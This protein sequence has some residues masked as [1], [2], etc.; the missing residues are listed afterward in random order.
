[1]CAI[2]A[3]RRSRRV[4]L[5]DHADKVGQ[6]ILISGGGRCNFT[7]LNVTPEN[8]LSQ[9]R[10]FCISALKRY[11]QHDFVA[12]IR[13]HNIPYH[14]R[15]DGQ[16]FCDRSSQDIINMLLKEC[17]D[18]NVVLI[19]SCGSLKVKKDSLFYIGSNRERF[20]AGSLVIATG[21]LSFQKKEAIGFGY[22]I[23]R[24]FGLNVVDL[25]PGL[26]PL[27]FNSKDIAS[28]ND[29]A[30]ISI[31]AAVSCNNKCFKGGILF[32]HR[33]ISGPPV[34][35]ISSYWDKDSYLVIDLIPDC[36][37]Y[38][39]LEKQR[40]ER[41]IVWLNTILSEL[42]P[43][44]LIER[45]GRDIIKN[46]Q[47]NQF[48]DKELKEISYFLQHWKIKPGGTEGYRTAEITVG[49]VD[50]NELSSKT[51]ES[52]KNNGL[53][54]IGEAVDVTGHLGGYNLQWAWSSGYC[55]G[56]FV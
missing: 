27:R 41:P 49:G 4:L 30:G 35:Q 48:S 43:K 46:R 15:E 54:F 17:R 6:K 7:N 10:H 31:N 3:G 2:E 40:C 42:L 29:L 37:L 12:L 32:T 18:A 21:G 50:T 1:M 45:I 39:L 34:L 56:Q 38:K 51:M 14:E 16:L 9:N 47:I 8:Y 13:R 24:Q 22:N 52:K 28:F 53:Y 5:L 55:A 26:V 19:K 20:S 11:T 44:R 33:G 23:A 36:D 25:R